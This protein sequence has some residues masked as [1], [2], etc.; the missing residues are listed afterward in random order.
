MTTSRSS[1]VAVGENRLW[2]M[3]H[4]E[5]LADHANEHKLLI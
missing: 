3:L 1:T 2:F 4:P 5:L